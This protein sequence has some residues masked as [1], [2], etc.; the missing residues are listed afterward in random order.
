MLFRKP[1]RCPDKIIKFVRS[2]LVIESDRRWLPMPGSVSMMIFF[3]SAAAMVT[4]GPQLSVNS[5]C[6]ELMIA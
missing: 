5:G 4:S 1:K 3:A 6:D 2:L